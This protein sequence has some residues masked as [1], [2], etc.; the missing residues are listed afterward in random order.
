VLD[1]LAYSGRPIG[2]W[3]ELVKKYDLQNH[4]TRETSI[5]HLME[6]SAKGSLV[7]VSR[8]ASNLRE[9]VTS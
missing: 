2:R 6:S 5:R 3:I 9:N 7:Q 8:F 1:K 4:K